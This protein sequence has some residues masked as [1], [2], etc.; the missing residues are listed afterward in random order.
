L[1]SAGN[2]IAAVGIP[3]SVTHLAVSEPNSQVAGA[4]HAKTRDAHA[5]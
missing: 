4:G 3:E 1:A 2:G 5:S